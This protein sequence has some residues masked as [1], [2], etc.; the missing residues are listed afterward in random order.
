MQ[1]PGGELNLPVVLKQLLNKEITPTSIHSEVLCR[2]C[3]KLI[4]EFDELQYR[5]GEIKKEISGNYQNTL[6]S[7]EAPGKAPTETK[8]DVM[9]TQ[10]KLL[11]RKGR[12]E[13]PK[14]IL[15]IPSSDDEDDTQPVCIQPCNH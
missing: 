5:M 14:K 2:K 13:L 11:T 10:E 8:E 4:D 12:N 7:N 9:E 3:Y 15:D 1:T 6:K